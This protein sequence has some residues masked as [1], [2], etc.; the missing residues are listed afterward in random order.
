MTT[1]FYR[2]PLTD[3]SEE[4]ILAIFDEEHDCISI[5]TETVGKSAS[6]PGIG[7]GVKYGQH[8]VYGTLYPDISPVIGA[9]LTKASNPRYKK[10]YHNSMFDIRTLEDFAEE[11]GFPIP[12]YNN[13][14]DTMILAQ[15]NGRTGSLDANSLEFNGWENPY[16]ISELL[17]A[18]GKRGATMLDV[19]T[20]QTA[21]KCMI[22]AE[23]TMGVY[24]GLQ[25]ITELR[26][27]DC[28][29]VDRQLIAVLLRVEKKGFF[30]DQYKLE[31]HSE[32]LKRESMVYRDHAEQMGF[33][34]GSN[35]QVGYVLASRGNM[36]PFTDNKR[37][38]KTD[39]DALEDL[40]DA[41]AHMVLAYRGTTK[42]LSTYVTPWLGQARAYTHFRIDLSTG[43]LASFDR[44]L[45]NV[46]PE[47]REIFLP[48]HGGFNWMDYSQI[49]M[50]VL[51]HVSQDKTLLLAFE[52]GVSPHEITRQEL[53]PSSTRYTSTGGDT[54]EYLRSKTFNFAMVYDAGINT[55][56]KRTGVERGVAAALR[57]KWLMTYTGVGHFMQMQSNKDVGYVTSE[58][59]RKMVLP[60]PEI[61]HQSHVDKCKINYVIQG[62]A[63]DIM[64]RS[65][66]QV[67]K[68]P[69]P[70]D[71]R[72]QVHDEMVVDG[73]YEFDDSLSRIHPELV[74]PFSASRGALWK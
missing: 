62:T 28:Y 4:E 31:A 43:R 41:V 42:L 3:P 68:V 30:L 36:L 23:M 49:E 70:P 33:E 12:D 53:W 57:K 67:M 39:A 21:I 19:P 73:E 54:V 14:E 35:Q 11:E 24:E 5:D 69:A 66:L 13:I 55:L 45:Q 9:I 32:R 6:D 20:Q 50:R 46:P 74:T 63:A 56:A 47:I 71:L 15:V 17:E 26:P 25:K 51:A 29:E 58:F 59:G 7:I 1:T 44:N 22:D 40:D 37:Q 64:K 2:G 65:M 8:C 61:R 60:D 38:L 34:I 16:K 72:L 48:D 27:R 18:V 52:N 10:I